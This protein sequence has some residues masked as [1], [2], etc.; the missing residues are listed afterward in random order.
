M[1]TARQTPVK[2]AEDTKGTYCH[3]VLKRSD[4]ILIL[5]DINFYNIRLIKIIIGLKKKTD[6][7]KCAR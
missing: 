5:K 1:F 3:V 6:V 7:T 4:A 2:L